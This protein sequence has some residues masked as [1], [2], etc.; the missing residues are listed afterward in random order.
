MFH[1]LQFVWKAH[2]LSSLYTLTH[3]KTF[4]FVVPYHVVVV[5][6]LNLPRPIRKNFFDKLPKNRP[7]QSPEFWI[8]YDRNVTFIMLVWY[9]I[10]LQYLKIKFTVYE[11]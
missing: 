2:F 4:N 10:R 1:W 7:I 11:N 5:V 9:N 6:G 8:L 3:A